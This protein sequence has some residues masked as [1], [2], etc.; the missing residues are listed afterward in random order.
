MI[1]SIIP[2]HFLFSCVLST[3]Y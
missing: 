2:P 1:N 3:L